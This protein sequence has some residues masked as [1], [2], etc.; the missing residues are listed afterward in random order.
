MD[1]FG[2]LHAP[3]P[4]ISGDLPEGLRQQR[5]FQKVL[6]GTAAAKK[7]DSTGCPTPDLLFLY[8]LVSNVPV[9]LAALVASFLSTASGTRPGSMIYGGEYVTAIAKG[10]GILKNVR[11]GLTKIPGASRVNMVS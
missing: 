6:C 11:R 8:A 7:D 1:D 10:M 4:D 2:V 3:L 9:N 5:V